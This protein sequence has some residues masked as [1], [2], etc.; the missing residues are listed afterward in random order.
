MKRSL[1]GLLALLGVGCAAHGTKP[2]EMSAQ[3]HQDEAKAA[4]AAASQHAAQYDPDA[5]AKEKKCHAQK[6][7]VV[8][9]TSTYNPTEEHLKQTKK[10]LDL[11]DE[12]RK[13]S[14]KL[15]D[16]EALACAGL[17]PEEVAI[18]PFFHREDIIRVEEERSAKQNILQGTEV[19]F[20]KVPGLT[21]DRFQQVLTCHLA[22]NA[23][24]GGAPTDMDYCPLALPGIKAEVR[25]T[26]EGFVVEVSS[27]DVETAKKSL[28][29]AQ[30]L[31][32]H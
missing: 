25:E 16:A 15:K 7:G 18:S 11:A 28:Q 5:E 27:S 9:W 13:A 17:S 1:L 29:R 6:G 8:C 4:E 23:S 24:M 12:H 20:V 21:Q 22:R 10:V 31:I 19:T 30:A 2:H 14:Q 26:T 32:T 3:K